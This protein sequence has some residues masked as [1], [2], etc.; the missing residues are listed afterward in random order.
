M[1]D[2]EPATLAVTDDEDP[3]PFLDDL[4]RR[5]EAAGRVVVAFSGGVDSAL[6]ARV[7]HD[8]LGPGGSLAVTAVSPSLAPAELD[9]CRRLADEWGMRWEQVHTDELSR[10]DYVSNG[11]DRCYHCKSELM[12]QLVP[13]AEAEG[14]MVALGVNLDDLSDHRPGQKAA[15]ERG[16]IF[17]LVDAGF[18]KSMVRG[19][20]RRLGLEVWDKPAA[21]CLASRLPY[22][23]PVTLTTLKGVA[24]AEERLR[25]LGFLQVRVRHYGDVARLE[26]PFDRLQEVL[27]AREDVVDAVKAGGYR[28]V[29]L[30]LEGFR[31]G[32]LNHPI[33]SDTQGSD[34]QG[35]DI[36][37]GA[38]R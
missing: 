22:G 33:V 27:D 32:N 29:T 10:P 25:R 34:I 15:R 6:L 37:D 11:P 13:V 36:Q 7:A 8:V 23:T 24:A 19:A 9:D 20:A 16:A 5:L 12:D 35:S 28:Y 21:A 17:P 18:T 30:D 3:T 26:V 38:V 1:T 4:R 2:H 31:S 14:A